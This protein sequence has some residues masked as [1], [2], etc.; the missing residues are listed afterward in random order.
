MFGKYNGFVRK[1][2]DSALM[3]SLVRNGIYH[4]LINPAWSKFPSIVLQFI[5]SAASAE[6]DVQVVY[7]EKAG[8]LNSQFIRYV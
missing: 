6:K 8:D 5:V 3:Y 7:V 4:A 1:T 2:R